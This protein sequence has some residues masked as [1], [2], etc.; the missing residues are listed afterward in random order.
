MIPPKGIR[1][2][3]TLSY[4]PNKDNYTKEHVHYP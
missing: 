2:V 4:V 1:N 3:Y